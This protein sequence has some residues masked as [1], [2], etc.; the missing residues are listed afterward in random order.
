MVYLGPHTTSKIEL[1]VTL[2]NSFQLLMNVIMNSIVDVVSIIM[3]LNRLHLKV[4]PYKYHLSTFSILIIKTIWISQ[5]EI[6]YLIPKQTNRN[7]SNKSLIGTNK[8]EINNELFRFLI[9]NV[10]YLI[11]NFNLLTLFFTFSLQTI[12]FNHQPHAMICLCL[13]NNI[14]KFLI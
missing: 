14:K 3:P 10:N 4:N 7:K 12:P 6:I 11:H 8:N 5:V 9:W 2:V 13:F 1:L